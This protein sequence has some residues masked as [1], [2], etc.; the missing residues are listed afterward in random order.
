MGRPNSSRETKFSGAIGEKENIFL[1]SADHEHDWQ[2]HSVGIYSAENANDLCVPP[3]AAVHSKQHGASIK[4]HSQLN[5]YQL[6][7]K[8]P[9]NKYYRRC[10]L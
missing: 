9:R 10:T 7:W 3:D 5:V 2:P 1:F 6:Y 8:L 4:Q